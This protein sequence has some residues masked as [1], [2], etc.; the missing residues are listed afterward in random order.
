MNA[1][2]HGLKNYNLVRLRRIEGIKDKGERFYVFGGL[3]LEGG[4]FGCLRFE[5][6]KGKR[7]RRLEDQKV[8]GRGMIG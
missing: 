6:G 1:D 3:R 2:G 7:I 8:S 5:A 4:T